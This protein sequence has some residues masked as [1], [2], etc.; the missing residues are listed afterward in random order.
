MKCPY[1]G[2][3]H[4]DDSK[5][6]SETG[7]PLQSQ[8]K[9][10][11]K[12]GYENVPVEAKF[13]PRCGNPFSASTKSANNISNLVIML[14]TGGFDEFKFID[15]NCN[16]LYDKPFKWEEHRCIRENF[17]KRTAISDPIITDNSKAYYISNTGKLIE[18]CT[19]NNQCKIKES[20]YGQYIL[21]V[22]SRSAILYKKDSQIGLILISQF[23][24]KYEV[25][26]FDI[27]GD[28]ISLFYN[29]GFTSINIK[30]GDKLD[31]PGYKYSM[32][33]AISG[34]ETITLASNDSEQPDSYV[35]L[36]KDENI[37]HSFPKGGYLPNGN[38][39]NPNII[40]RH[41][42]TMGL[43]GLV[44]FYGEEVIPPYFYNIT[45]QDENHLLLHIGDPYRKWKNRILEY[46]LS[47]RSFISNCY[48][49]DK[50]KIRCRREKLPRSF[51][52][53]DEF[54]K[55]YRFGFGNSSDLMIEDEEAII[56]RTD[57]KVIYHMDENEY[58]IGASDSLKRFGMYDR[59]YITIYDNEGK[60][61]YEHHASEGI[62]NP[63]LYDN[64]IVLFFDCE[65]KELCIIDEELKL[66]IVQT[67][68]NYAGEH[69]VISTNCIAVSF[70]VG[71]KQVYKLYNI[72]GEL[73]L[74][75][76]MN[77]ISW[78]K[79]NER[80]VILDI[81]N[82]ETEK[83]LCYNEK[84]GVLLNLQDNKFEQIPIP[85][86]NAYILK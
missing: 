26:S 23:R 44:S 39:D 56:R 79:L 15:K 28:Y 12:C 9:K 43:M 49:D 13:C 65:M 27:V 21:V 57:K 22:Q 32:L 40:I 76:E 61:L 2:Q 19:Y 47:D 33:L 59:E 81:A 17:D 20:I 6:C 30:T 66:T 75:K 1:C 58:P 71:Q 55:A 42:N 69:D 70:W 14:E 5:F 68:N 73:I 77:V 80:F 52:E 51:D 11:E 37:I 8:T 86:V 25:Y 46:D 54:L 50:Q 78:K 83:A 10:C 72:K 18:I 7:K 34:N 16:L 85:Y 74:P 36:G 48:L 38:S 62:D 35:V 31:I 64:G 63:R 24:L 67:D 82:S 84:R 3:E 45:N 60:V 29:D 41:I 53:L 4:P